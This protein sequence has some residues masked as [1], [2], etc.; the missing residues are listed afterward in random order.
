MKIEVY[1][2]PAC[3]RCLAATVWLAKN[4]HPFQEREL[5]DETAASPQI[6]IDG[7]PIGGFSELLRLDLPFTSS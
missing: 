2:R 5:E 3:A 4:G 6:F 1:T 7:R